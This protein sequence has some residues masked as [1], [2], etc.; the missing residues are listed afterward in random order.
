VYDYRWRLVP[1]WVTLPGVVLG[2]VL[3]FWTLGV[4]SSLEG[5][6]LALAIY[7]SLFLLRALGAGDVKLMAAV[8]AVVGPGPWLRIFLLTALCGGIAALV[9]I[10]VRGRFRHTLW[11]TGLIL[12]SITRGQAPHK[13][14]PELDVRTT[15]GMRLPHA[16][17]I[18]C[19]TVLYLLLLETLGLRP[20]LASPV[21]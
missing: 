8:G 5:L 11:N 19:G 4:W 17:M 6:G 7:G 14:S 9:L 18:A 21:P 20:G 1:N 13:L 15:A 10:L 2:I 12:A 3:S 16:V